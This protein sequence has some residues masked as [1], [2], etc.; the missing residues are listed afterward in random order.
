MDSFELSKIAGA[1]LA[2]LLLIVGPNVIISARTATPAGQPLAGYALPTTTTEAAG[3]AAPAGAAGEQK[4][5]TSAAP[6]APTAAPA[7]G[8]EAAA[9]AAAPAAAGFD[10]KAVVALLA[11]AKPEE[12][13]ALFKKCASC[14]VVKKDAPSAVAPNLWGIVNRPKAAQPDFAT[15]YSE[16]IKA[17]GGEWTYE[18]LA[19]FIHQPK[20]YIAGTKMLFA[21]IKDPNEIA[22]IIAYLRTLADAPAP[23]PK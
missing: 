14:H 5:E 8:K 20:G 9:P 22:Q 17:K 1:V 10:A 11:S 23:L 4:A 18:N 3:E 16:A 13:A 2:A 19:L 15:K 6:A 12:G 21:G 7:P